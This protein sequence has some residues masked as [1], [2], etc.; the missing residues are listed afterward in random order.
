M[1]SSAEYAERIVEATDYADEP[2]PRVA[3]LLAEWNASIDKRFADHNNDPTVREVDESL[4]YPPLSREAAASDRLVALTYINDASDMIQKMD[5]ADP[6]ERREFAEFAAHE[7][8]EVLFPPELFVEAADAELR[9]NL[10]GILNSSLARYHPEGSL[11]YPLETV[12]T[13]FAHH[14]S[15]LKQDPDFPELLQSRRE[16]LQDIAADFLPA[17]ALNY[18]AADQAPALAG[19]AERVLSRMTPGTEEHKAHS[20]GKTEREIENENR[21]NA[22]ALRDAFQDQV[23][24]SRRHFR[25][26]A[27]DLAQ[28]LFQDQEPVNAAEDAALRHIRAELADWLRRPYD[29]DDAGWHFQALQ[30]HMAHLG[31]GRERQ[32][33]TG[34]YPSLQQSMGYQEEPSPYRLSWP[35]GTLLATADNFREALTALDLDPATGL[36]WHHD[37]YR[38]NTRLAR[39]GSSALTHAYAE[40]ME[41]AYNQNRAARREL[42]PAAFAALQDRQQAV[43]AAISDQLQAGGIPGYTDLKEALRGQ[44]GLWSPRAQRKSLGPEYDHPGLESHRYR[45]LQ[46]HLDNGGELPPGY[47]DEY[48]KCYDQLHDRYTDLLRE[49]SP[50]SN[51]E[52]EHLFWECLEKA[53]C[54]EP[55]LQENVLNAYA[56]E[57][58]TEEDFIAVEPPGDFNQ[59]MDLAVARRSP[60]YTLHS[61]AIPSR[62]G[63][64]EDYADPELNELKKQPGM[65]DLLRWIEKRYTG[66][67]YYDHD[68]LTRAEHL[69]QA[70][71]LKD[72]DNRIKARA[73]ARAAAGAA[74]A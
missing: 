31:H 21:D 2:P 36:R 55:T 59:V 50:F 13:Q 64:P 68:F 39:G 38:S 4:G 27:T 46:E 73:A 54:R 52:L 53:D 66:Y 9:E 63:R 56:N 26:A 30:K 24:Y 18:Y 14:L 61:N 48:G 65:N 12:I 3:E 40:V 74:A 69:N 43:S 28:S 19:Y 37:S 1:P 25:T 35:A 29:G 45:L 22:D 34:E 44:S 49:H 70:Q 11:N 7:M 8:A 6:E 47:G 72:L 10:Q 42:D 57:K 16:I 60:H 71:I 32:A 23:F 51:R 58:I 20:A 67:D 5:F 41:A 15:Q 17:E 33:A 62:P